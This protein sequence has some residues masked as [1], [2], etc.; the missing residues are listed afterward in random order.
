MRTIK[1]NSKFLVDGVIWTLESVIP[2]MEPFLEPVLIA[3]ANGKTI[4]IALS[5]VKKW[6]EGGVE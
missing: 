6:I 4:Y 5:R 2:G 1:A 3:N